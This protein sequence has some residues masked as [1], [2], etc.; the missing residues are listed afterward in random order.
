[1]AGSPLWTRDFIKK[2]LKDGRCDDPIDGILHIYLNSWI[3]FEPFMNTAQDMSGAIYRGVSNTKYS[4]IPKLFRDTT[5]YW[6]SDTKDLILHQYQMFSSMIRGRRGMNPKQLTVIDTWALG[7]HYGLATPLLDWTYSPFVA[8]YFAFEQENK[9]IINNKLSNQ[10]RIVYCLKKWEIEK[11]DNNASLLDLSQILKIRD[12]SEYI[13]FLYPERSHK[14][15]KESINF[16][17][18]KIGF[19]NSLSDENSRLINQSGLFTLSHGCLNLVEW[20][21]NDFDSKNRFKLFKRKELDRKIKHPW[22]LMKVEIPCSTMRDKNN[23][24]DRE[25]CLTM[26]NRMNINRST[27]FPDLSGAADC[28]N[29]SLKIDD[30]LKGEIGF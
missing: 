12:I 20:V 3:D 11:R 24:N 30:Y 19:Y 13:N 21:K 7:Q 6:T 1:M 9:A 29:I 22:L 16:N 18:D 8:L 4:L 17:I 14:E 10:S 28:T 15:L 26:L 25:N 27:L 2:H 5:S 23:K